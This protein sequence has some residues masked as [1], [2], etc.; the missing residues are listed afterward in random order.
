MPC[1]ID[2]ATPQAEREVRPVGSRDPGGHALRRGPRTLPFAAIVTDLKRQRLVDL[3]HRG[4]RPRQGPRV[5]RLS[6]SREAERKAR[7]TGS[8]SGRR[9]P[10]ACTVR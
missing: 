7:A 10:Q 1:R 2:L 3:D 8:R 4:N 5:P 9:A 6:A